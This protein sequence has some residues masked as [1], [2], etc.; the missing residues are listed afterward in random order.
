[1]LFLSGT[2]KKA[3]LFRDRAHS[4]RWQRDGRRA[5]FPQ[6]HVGNRSPVNSSCCELMGLRAAPAPARVLSSS[7]KARVYAAAAGQRDGP[8]TI[9]RSSCIRANDAISFSLNR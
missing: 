6:T 4:A 2:L 5:A 1:M 3:F 7:T 9:L 8:A